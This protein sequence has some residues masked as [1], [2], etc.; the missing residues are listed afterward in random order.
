MPL[1]R[2]DA[3]AS[4][5]VLH[6]QTGSAPRQTQ[7]ALLAHLHRSLDTLP[8][9]APIVILVHG[10]KFSPFARR[11]NP[12]THLFS[13]TPPTR[14]WKALSWPA[15]LGFTGQTPD[16]GLC[17][18]IGWEGRGSIWAAWQR[19]EAA[20]TA[21][22]WL[23]GKIQAR[24]RGPVHLLAHS[25]GARV[26]IAALAQS[27]VGS[28]GRMI[29]LAGAEF[30]PTAQAALASPAG[31]SAD[32]INVTS[33]ENDPYDAALEWL[34]QAPT[35]GARVLGQGFAAPN[36]VT[37]QI[38]AAPTRRALADLGIIVPEPSRAICHWS[39]Y[40]RPG[41][42]QFY[43]LALRERHHVS[44]PDLRRRLPAT[45][46]PRWS[47][48][49]HTLPHLPSTLGPLTKPDRSAL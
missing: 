24:R 23:I 14:C 2:V 21:L 20:G 18:P 6:R 35:K 10:Y 17:L 4:G 44:I 49:R 7:A 12:H 33:R 1:L 8:P 47:R 32:L 30:V 29:L 41:L 19:A 31:Q 42:A 34:I 40:L 43:S 11:A 5:A 45:N 46:D 13:L 22:A 28:V 36:A 15:A 48:L 38:D 37:L 26:C 27:P 9:G 39:T 3:S 16:E 25:L